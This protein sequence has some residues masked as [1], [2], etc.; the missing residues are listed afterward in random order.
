MAPINVVVVL[1]PLVPVIAT[2][3][4]AKKTIGQFDLAEHRNRRAAASRSSGFSFGTPGLGI[5][6]IDAVEPAVFF[7]A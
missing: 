3:G 5:T 1:L 4:R 6:Q 2:I 7:P